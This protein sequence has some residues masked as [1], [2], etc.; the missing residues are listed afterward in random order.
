MEKI[1]ENTID[2]SNGEINNKVINNSSDCEDDGGIANVAEV[3]NDEDVTETNTNE[4]TIVEENFVDVSN[5]EME[6][7][8]LKKD[9]ILDNLDEQQ[10]IELLKDL[11]EEISEDLILN[12]IKRLKIEKQN[13]LR[14]IK[15]EKD[16]LLKRIKKRILCKK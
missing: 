10:K 13:I 1:E 11:L 14:K 8:P 16:S 3:V 15:I 5:I 12:V 2:L 4:N 6:E 9:N 7:I